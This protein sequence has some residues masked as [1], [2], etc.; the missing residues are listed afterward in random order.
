MELVRANTRPSDILT[1]D[2]FE[3]AIA[4]VAGT[5]G[6]TNGVLHLLAIARE[7]GIPLSIDDFDTIA[8][9]TPIVAD[10][11]PFGRYVA[12]DLQA[13][14]GVGLVA[15]ELVGA[16]LHPRRRA[17]RRRPHDRRRRHGGR[18]DGR[19]RTSSSRSRRRSRPPAA[20]RSCAAR[21]RP[22][23]A[24]SS[25]PA[26][27]GCTSARPGARVRLR[28]GVL[29]GRQGAAD[30]AGRR[31][32]DPLRG[33]VRRPRHARDAARDRRA[34]RRGASATRSR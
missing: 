25:S 18:R 2:A 14:G 20:S 31:G 5:G 7:V 17:R 21:S 12:T 32:R 26:T 6:S 11:K 4:A 15:R 27:S 9:H 28:G 19:A 30:Q 3:N 33:P 10:L 29:R 22:R 8:A 23:A 34:R 1:R 13:A 16:G 24:S